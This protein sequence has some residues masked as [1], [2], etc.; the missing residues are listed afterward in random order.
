MIT[1]RKGIR[2]ELGTEFYDL[3][4]IYEAMTT[5]K[6]QHIWEVYFN[7]TNEAA[8]RLDKLD[9]FTDKQKK[10]MFKDFLALFCLIRDEVG[11]K[12]IPKT[13]KA[14]KVMGKITNPYLLSQI[15]YN[16]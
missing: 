5:K 8:E 6:P 16:A 13:K 14:A 4:P 2:Q 12:G 10:L 1:T 11:D 7:V 9:N 15:T 3:Y